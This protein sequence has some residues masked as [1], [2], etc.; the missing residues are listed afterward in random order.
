MLA[1]SAKLI[2]GQLNKKHISAASPQ[3]S[4]AEDYFA[5]LLPVLKVGGAGAYSTHK[6]DLR[7]VS[8]HQP[9]A[10]VGVL[11]VW[12][13]GP[14]GCVHSL[15]RAL[16][17]DVSKAYRRAGTYPVGRLGFISPGS[18]SIVQRHLVA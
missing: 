16:H 17:H 4:D 8:R 3:G 9:S 1:A 2:D 10:T 12:S 6:A 7:S 13:T 18:D 11:D 5:K 15:W 14:L